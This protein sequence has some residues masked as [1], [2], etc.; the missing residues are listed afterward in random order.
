[1]KKK[2]FLLVVSVQ[3][4]LLFGIGAVLSTFDGE[5]EALG[6]LAINLGV[7][8]VSAQIG[9]I[10]HELGHW[11]GARLVGEYPRRLEFGKGHILLRT[12]FFKTKLNIYHKLRS[13][14]I[15]TIFAGRKNYRIRRF[16]YVLMGP[17]ANLLLAGLFFG[18]FPLSSNFAQEV[19][20]GVVGG[21]VNVVMFLVNLWPHKTLVHNIPSY[22]DGLQIWNLLFS[23]KKQDGNDYLL[24]DFMDAED[25]LHA[26]DYN[27]ALQLFEA[28]LAR[29]DDPASEIRS[30][31]L[32]NAGICKGQLGDINGYFTLVKSVEDE[33]GSEIP[34]R[35]AGP[36]Y[37]NLALIYMLNEQ[38]EDANRYVQR[39]MK[40]F[41]GQLEVRLLHGSLLVVSGKVDEGIEV[42]MPV[43][44]FSL[45][46]MN[47]LA[48]A[49]YLALAYH[50]KG[51][52]HQK[53]KY[54]KFVGQHE[55]RL[56]GLGRQM[57]DSVSK[58]LA[59]TQNRALADP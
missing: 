56:H 21:M 29:I 2:L 31:C 51:K 27:S 52:D 20:I 48:G 58:R 45:P 4:L 44:D 8:F 33:L 40:F 39:A 54:L 14:H 35:L 28:C 12:H 19:C 18:A 41:P 25:A 46:N 30:A 3:S 13:A 38:L 16:I 9:T 57:Y 5:W 50:L 49:M 10:V 42:L 32:V 34:D 43:V 23:K 17:V 15:I 22:S 53:E 11:C 26:G 37:Q 6:F 24:N 7:M 36:I 59:I 47:T 55:Q 1:M